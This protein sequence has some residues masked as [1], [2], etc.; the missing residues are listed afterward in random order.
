[1]RR[2]AAL[3]SLR[4]THST[5]PRLLLPGSTAAILDRDDT[6]TDY[7]SQ[8]HN[9]GGIVN[10]FIN[11]ARG[12]VFLLPLLETALCNAQSWGHPAGGCWNTLWRAGTTQGRMRNRR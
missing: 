1:M 7:D 2:R 6:L 5:K 9:G 4:T 12:G 10:E 11:A 3:L 8:P